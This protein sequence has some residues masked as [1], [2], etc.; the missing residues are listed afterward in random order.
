MPEAARVTVTLNWHWLLVL[1]VAPDRAIPVGAVVVNVPPHTVAEALA[2][3]SPVGSVSVKATPVK[4]A[5][6][7]AGLV[8]VKV[9]EVVAFRAIVDGLKTLAI[10]GGASTVN[11]AV[12][13]VAPVPPSVE[14]TVPVV[15]LL[16]PAVVPVTSTEKVHEE[17][18]AGDA[19]SVPPERLMVL[20]PANAVIV[21]LP[22]EPV[23]LGVAATTTPAGKLSVKATPLSALAV[24]GL[25]MVKLSVLVAFNAMLVGLKALLMVGGATTVRLAVLLAVPVPPSVELMA[26]VVL[27]FTPAVVPVTSTENVHDDPAAGDAVSVPPDKLMAP[28]PATAVIVPLPQEPVTLGVAATT[29]PAGRC[30][31]VGHRQARGQRVSKR[32]SCQ[33]HRVFCWIGDGEGQRRRRIQR[34]GRWIK[35]LGN[36]WRRNYGQ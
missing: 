1:I 15:L 12:L 35:D 22:H 8:M 3:V 30:G 27:S 20:L 25:V 14:L 23:T 10:E 18:A 13:L 11:I 6:L 32:N 17:P 31:G 34:N 29:R 21:P 2:T 5:A 24:F 16:L 36:R 26:P 28:L 4:A 9:S 7:A 33:R 19:V